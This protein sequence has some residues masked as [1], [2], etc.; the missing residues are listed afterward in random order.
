MRGFETGGISARDKH[1][2]D[3]LG[4]NWMWRAKRDAVTEE[5][6]KNLLDYTQIYERKRRV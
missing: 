2:K 1:T 6:K 4:G 3:A 5:I